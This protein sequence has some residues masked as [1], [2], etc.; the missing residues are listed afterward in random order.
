[1]R[2]LFLIINFE[3]EAASHVRESDKN[4]LF[5]EVQSFYTP[6]VETQREGYSD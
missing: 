5:E 6:R 4:D 2:S 1:M 3:G